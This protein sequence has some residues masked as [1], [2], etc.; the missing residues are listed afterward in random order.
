MKR[1]TREG[2]HSLPVADPKILHPPPSCPDPNLHVTHTERIQ[3]RAFEHA[4]VLAPWSSGS[5]S[6]GSWSGTE[7]AQR[8]HRGS[9]EAAQRQHRGSTE[10]FQPSA[11]VWIPHLLQDWL[12]DEP[13]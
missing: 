10:D 3:E 6:K 8:Q 7:A 5:P 13:G 9:P 1:T 11:L 12:D 2:R 4:V